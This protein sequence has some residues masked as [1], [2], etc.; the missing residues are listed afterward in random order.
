[1]PSRRS[2][3]NVVAIWALC[4]AAA[5]VPA[6]GQEPVRPDTTGPDTTRV[7]QL[8][9]LNVTVTRSAE[10]VTVTLSSGS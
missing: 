1:M 3:Y 5:V 8:P 6:R 4:S 2:Y 10:R 7:R 9:E